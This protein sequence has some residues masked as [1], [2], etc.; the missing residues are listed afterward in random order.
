MGNKNSTTTKSAPPPCNSPSVCEPQVAYVKKQCEQAGK[1][2]LQ[3]T[4]RRTI[5]AIAGPIYGEQILNTYNPLSQKIIKQHRWDDMQPELLLGFKNYEGF[6]E[7]ASNNNCVECSCSAAAEKI[8]SECR[9]VNPLVPDAIVSAINDGPPLMS[10]NARHSMNIGP[11]PAEPIF[12]WDTIYYPGLFGNTAQIVANANVNA[13]VNTN[14]NVNANT[15]ANANTNVNKN[16]NANKNTKESFINNNDGKIY[17]F[18][19]D[20]I[21]E[22]HEKFKSRTNFKADCDKS[23]YY[24][25]NMF[26]TE[27]KQMLDKLFTYYTTLVSSYESQYLHKEA[28][29]KIINSKLDELEKIQSKIDSYKTNLHVDNRKNNYQNN[30]YEFYTSVKKYMLILYYSLFVLYLIFSNFL[31]EKQYTNKKILL[32]LA[33]YLLIPIVLSFAINLTYEG[34]IYFLESNNIKED[35]KSYA[36]IIKA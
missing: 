32:V 23:A 24:S 22:R 13:N 20:A 1:G 12:K 4:L 11:A 19:K 16:L 14:A 28:V 6:K 5:I 35:T 3:E 26:I 18:V 29:T 30:N 36:D 10:D 2:A 7:G 31:R 15:N 34:Y 8:I 17:K 33:I 27:E 9:K 25:M 21:Q